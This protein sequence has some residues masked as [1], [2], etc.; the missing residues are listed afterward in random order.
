MTPTEAFV[1]EES[2]G[3]GKSGW[4]PIQT[5]PRDGTRILAFMS[6]VDDDERGDFYGTGTVAIIEWGDHCYAG[7]SW[8]LDREENWAARCD[9]TVWMPLPQ[10]PEV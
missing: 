7:P 6:D 4:M 1:T 10:P 8:L 3:N 5:A 2:G 9:P